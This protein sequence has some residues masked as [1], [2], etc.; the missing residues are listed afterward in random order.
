[1]LWIE[2]VKSN[3]SIYCDKYGYEKG[4]NWGIQHNKPSKFSHW[5]AS[6]ELIKCQR[7]FLL[8]DSKLKGKGSKETL[9]NFN[10]LLLNL[11]STKGKRNEENQSN[12]HVSI[13][14]LVKINVVRI[15]TKDKNKTK[16]K[17]HNRILSSIAIIPTEGCVFRLFYEF[18]YNVTFGEWIQ[19]NGAD[20]F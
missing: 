11:F 18:L 1:M 3:G 15:V 12:L 2:H 5:T 9:E 7:F 16:K 20:H 8:F 4:P 6:I 17:E 19:H 10:Q 14:T 13:R